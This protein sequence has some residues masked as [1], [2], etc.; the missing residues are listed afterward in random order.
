MVASTIV[1]NSSFVLLS[2]PDMLKPFEW[3]H[4]AD[5]FSGIAF[6]NARRTASVSVS[7]GVVVEFMCGAGSDALQS[8]PLGPKLTLTQRYSPSLYGGGSCANIMRTRY[9]PEDELPS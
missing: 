8:V 5:T 3:P 6:S 4:E 1:T 7:I 2:R 9:T